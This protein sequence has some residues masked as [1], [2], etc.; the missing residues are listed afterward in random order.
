MASLLP[1][2]SV[3]AKKKKE[4]GNNIVAIAYCPATRKKKAYK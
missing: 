2:P 3:M 4:E 1:S